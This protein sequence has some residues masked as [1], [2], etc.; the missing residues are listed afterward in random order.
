[1]PK[2]TLHLHKKKLD[3]KRNYWKQVSLTGR[4]MTSITLSPAVK[5]SEEITSQKSRKLLRLKVFK[6]F[7]GTVKFSGRELMNC[8]KRKELL[9]KFKLDKKKSRIERFTMNCCNGKLPDAMKSTLIPTFTQNSNLSFTL[10]KPIAT[11]L[12]I[13]MKWVWKT[14]QW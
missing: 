5:S 9:N 13:F 6:R 8:L 7:K 12:K 4:R 14:C 3:W 11:W 10:S 1:M 2:T